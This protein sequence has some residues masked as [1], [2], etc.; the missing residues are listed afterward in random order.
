MLRGGAGVECRCRRGPVSASSR[1]RRLF[2][3]S[4]SSA[5]ALFD[6]LS[7]FLI[8]VSYSSVELYN[9]QRAQLELKSAVVC[10]TNGDVR[11]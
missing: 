9:Y 3:L 4:L 6:R 5:I 1:H 10:V 8:S 11:L 7:F 2:Y